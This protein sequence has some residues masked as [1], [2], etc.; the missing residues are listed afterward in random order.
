V[1]VS[2]R[3]A[4]SKASMLPVERNGVDSIHVATIAMALE[5]EVPSASKR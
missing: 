1:V 5:R 2:V 3:S 4:C